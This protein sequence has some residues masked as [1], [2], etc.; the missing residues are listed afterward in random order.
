M[1]IMNELNKKFIINIIDKFKWFLK[2]HIIRNYS[3]KCL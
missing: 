1:I 2:M 3:I